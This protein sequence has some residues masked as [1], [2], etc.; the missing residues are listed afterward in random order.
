MEANPKHLN[1]YTA[2]SWMKRK[3]RGIT[4]EY[5]GYIYSSVG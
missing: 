2:D 4:K 5:F 1:L 3:E